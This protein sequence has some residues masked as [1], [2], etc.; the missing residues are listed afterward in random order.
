M[1]FKQTSTWDKQLYCPVGE[2]YNISFL[3]LSFT[4]VCS[5][6]CWTELEW[7]SESTPP[8]NTE[9]S[10]G[11]NYIKT[12]SLQPWEPRQRYHLSQF[13]EKLTKNKWFQLL[14]G[15]DQQQRFIKHLFV[16]CSYFQYVQWNAGV[17]HC[18]GGAER[19]MCN[20]NDE[21]D[22]KNKGSGK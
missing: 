16:T 1:G 4:S 2:D 15:K 7:W 10:D 9:R 17:V 11:Q 13:K 6:F 22:S 5:G 20:N 19:L 3:T 14:T 21:N 12:E 18:R 8:L